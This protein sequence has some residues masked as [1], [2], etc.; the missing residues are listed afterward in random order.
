MYDIL[1]CACDKNSESWREKQNLGKTRKKSVHALFRLLLTMGKARVGVRIKDAV[2]SSK[3]NNRSAD[4]VGLI[5]AFKVM[6]Q[7]LGY[8]VGAL[9][10]HHALMVAISASRVS[11]SRFYVISVGKMTF[12]GA[13][14][15]RQRTSSELLHACC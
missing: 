8:L 15:F 7:K 12:F 11:V 2:R 10:Q 9:R 13:R 1:A 14:S 4:L 3:S 6:K 5:E